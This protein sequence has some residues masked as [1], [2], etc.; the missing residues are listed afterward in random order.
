MKAALVL[1]TLVTGMVDAV[2]FIQLGHVFVANMTGNVVFLGFSAAGFTG[3]SAAGSVIA[4]AA[5]LAGALAGGRLVLLSA[6]H[7]HLLRNA[8]LVKAF[9]VALA[10]IVAADLPLFIGSPGWAALIA[11]LA[12]TMGI[13][14]AAA[15]KLAVPDLTTTVLTM[16]LTGIAADSTIAGGNNPRWA[17][18]IVAIVSMFVGALI[19]AL[20]VLRAGVLPVLAIVFVV[21]AIASVS[22]HRAA[23]LPAARS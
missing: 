23:M 15:R 20:V 5:F 21:F 17:R 11:L 1:L 14:N 2:S 10:I 12:F 18:R 13:Q 16:T 7:E 22:M 3:V 4:L 6:R 19:G 9:L 8:T